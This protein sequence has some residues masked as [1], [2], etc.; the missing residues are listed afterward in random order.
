MNLKLKTSRSKLFSK[1]PHSK[2]A[3]LGANIPPTH[4]PAISILKRGMGM[5]PKW[6]AFSVFCVY[7]TYRILSLSYH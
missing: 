6:A 7:P 3:G 2:I 5:C 4:N 1:E